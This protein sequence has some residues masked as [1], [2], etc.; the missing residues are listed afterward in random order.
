MLACFA[1]HNISKKMQQHKN[2]VI[3]SHA[4]PAS[5]KKTIML[6]QALPH[7]N[8]KSLVSGLILQSAPPPPT[9]LPPSYHLIKVFN[10]ISDLFTFHIIK[11][12]NL[13]DF[14]ST[15]KK[16]LIGILLLTFLKKPAH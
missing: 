1:D 2:F 15:K 4:T 16:S 8:Y 11:D 9:R 3:A 12:K 5:L 13:F 10:T 6:A 14:K 7:K